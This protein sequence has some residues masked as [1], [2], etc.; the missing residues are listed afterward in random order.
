M[1]DAN[2]VLF[3]N[4]IFIEFWQDFV[5]FRESAW[6]RLLDDV[7]LDCQIEYLVGHRAV[8]YLDREGY[9]R[10]SAAHSLTLACIASAISGTD[11]GINNA[12]ILSKLVV[13]ARQNGINCLERDH[14]AMSP[15]LRLLHPEPLSSNS[16]R[17]TGWEDL[18]AVLSAWLRLLQ[19]L[20]IDL[21]AYGEEEWRLFQSIRRNY[22][23]KRPWDTW[24]GP[25]PHSCHEQSFYKVKCIYPEY[26]SSDELDRRPAL[27]SFS[28]GATISDW[29]IWEIHPGDQY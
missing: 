3:W 22:D 11:D 10:S 27:F 14:I 25:Q 24:H 16:R 21:A 17:Y 29:N 20:G 18:S 19:Q 2:I 28:Y 7:V 26:V 23:C 5:D 13:E 15:M 4:A 9:E 1:K 12:R 8:D 6:S